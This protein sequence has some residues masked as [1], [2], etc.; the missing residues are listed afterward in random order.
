M[1]VIAM[2]R[3]LLG[4]I[5]V[6]SLLPM[7]GASYEAIASASDSRDYPAPG[8]LIDVGGYRLHLNCTGDGA[9]TLI[10]EA[11]LGGNSLN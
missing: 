3:I 11:G 4:T 8:E 2:L 5:A 10:L 6:L 1:K 9:P 7:A